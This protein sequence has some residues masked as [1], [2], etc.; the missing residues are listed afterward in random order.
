MKET[1]QP[2]ITVSGDTQEEID[3]QFEALYQFC[4]SRG[5][6]VEEGE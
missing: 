5:I 2:K 3:E 6:E 1:R 4:Y